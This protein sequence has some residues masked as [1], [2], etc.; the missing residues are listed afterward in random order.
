[1]RRRGRSP[2]S[3]DSDDTLATES[4]GAGSSS[5]ALL[6][7]A[8]F[9]FRTMSLETHELLSKHHE[10]CLH[11]DLLDSC[12]CVCVCMIETQPLQR[13]FCFES[14]PRGSCFVAM[15]LYRLVDNLIQLRAPKARLW[16]MWCQCPKLSG[17]RAS[18]CNLIFMCSCIA[19]PRATEDTSK[20]IR[21]YSAMVHIHACG[22]L[23]VW[24]QAL[25]DMT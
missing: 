12:L 15:D 10:L 21:T 13:H 1:M 6:H 16:S 23:L 17:F 25:F 5:W 9:G 18:K 4:G 8:L 7:I 22:P 14:E 3:V 19:H 20:Y 11:I 24:T 2:G